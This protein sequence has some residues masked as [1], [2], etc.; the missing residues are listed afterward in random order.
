MQRGVGEYT[1]DVYNLL[2]LEVYTGP[3][4]VFI[5]VTY[6]GFYEFW[7]TSLFD[8]GS[9]TPWRSA[10]IPAKSIGELTFTLYQVTS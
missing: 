1:D 5:E 3:G 6:V 7:G 9:G 10:S 2:A 8:R 4:S